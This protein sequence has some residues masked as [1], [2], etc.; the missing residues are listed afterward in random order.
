M[1]KITVREIAFYGIL[2]ALAVFAGYIETL[3]AIPSPVAGVKI[4]IGNIVVLYA[5]CIRGKKCAVIVC[6]VKV[7][8]C[9]LLFGNIMTMLYSASGAFL[10]LAA[11]ITAVRFTRAGIV[12]ISML[13]GVFHNVGQVM[14][15][16][17]FL[18]AV[19]MIYLPFLAAVGGVCGALTGAA[20]AVIVRRTEGHL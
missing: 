13:G 19:T 3:F 9:A 16:C 4:G 11:M 20:A 15:A 14:C 6:I 1:M 5:L 8:A 7:L 2:S 12:G 17:A 18:G 10:S